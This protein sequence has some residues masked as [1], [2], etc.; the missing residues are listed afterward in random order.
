MGKLTNR[1]FIFL[2]FFIIFNIS[3]EKKI[4]L[5]KQDIEKIKKGLFLDSYMLSQNELFYNRSKSLNNEIEAE[6]NIQRKLAANEITLTNVGFFCYDLGYA[7][8]VIWSYNNLFSNANKDTTKYIV[9]PYAF[10]YQTKYENDTVINYSQNKGG[11]FA[12]NPSIL[13][14]DSHPHTFKNIKDITSVQISKS[15]ALYDI[16]IGILTDETTYEG[17]KTNL[18]SEVDLFCTYFVQRLGKVAECA[19]DLSELKELRKENPNKGI[20]LLISP[21]ILNNRNFNF[22]N[23][24]NNFGL[25]IIPDHV[26]NTEDII[27]NDLTQNGIN[28]IKAFIENGGNI[29]ATGKSGFLLE[30]F[31]LVNNGFYKTDKYLYSLKSTESVSNQA[32][33]SL[34]GCENIPQK[35]P[36]EQPDYFKQLMCM[37]MDYKIF[38]TSV[39][40]MDE[41]KFNADSNWNIVMSLKSNEIGSNLKYKDE[42]GNDIDLTSEDTFFPI[43]I[44]KQE[45]KK[46]RIIIINGNLFVNTDYTFQLIMDSVFYSM[47]KNVIF[48]AYIKYSDGSNEDL[49]IPGGEEGVRL[50]CHFKFLNMYE[51]NIEEIS[52]DVFVALK[53]EV[54]SIPTECQKIIND[55][56]KYSSV[57]DMDIT[58]YIRCSLSK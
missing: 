52:V 36:S 6:K 20:V 49:P 40:T 21:S 19:R 26:Y 37:N 24:E 10:D 44:T 9:Y 7:T 54:T 31:G 15:K 43:V 8:R 41:T 58:Y 25:L 48:D 12:I 33:V 34:T 17:T 45:D 5:T 39:Y 57:E 11:F 16:D 13:P 4:K 23:D 18:F 22:K 1:L 28:K 46:G 2:T 38:L 42:N 29:L 30:K 55:K 50:N 47:G 32:L 51:T 56:K 27:I 53:T 35:K 3:Y 14:S